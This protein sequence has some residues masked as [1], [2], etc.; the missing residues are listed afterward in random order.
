MGPVWEASVYSSPR[1]S[2]NF[3]EATSLLPC[4]QKRGICPNQ[5]S[6]INSAQHF[7][8]LFL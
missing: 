4:L 3:I 6:Q 7:P 5:K 2:Q 1:N 8:I